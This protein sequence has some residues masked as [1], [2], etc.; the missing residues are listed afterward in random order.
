MLFRCYMVTHRGSSVFLPWG[1]EPAIYE[2]CKAEEGKEIQR[3][4]HRMRGVIQQN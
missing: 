4:G 2:A 3:H 1:L